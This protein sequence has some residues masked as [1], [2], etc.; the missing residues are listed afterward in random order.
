MIWLLIICMDAAYNDH[1]M[2]PIQLVSREDCQRIANAYRVTN[3]R[4]NYEGMM[5]TQC[6][7]VRP[8]PSTEGR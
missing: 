7:Q 1:C 2:A 5:A 6:I 8:R 4:A 3:A